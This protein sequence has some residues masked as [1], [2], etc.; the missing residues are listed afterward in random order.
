MKL[1][2]WRQKVHCIAASCLPLG[3]R[4]FGNHL[5]KQKMKFTRMA[6]MVMMIVLRMVAG[7]GVGDKE[8]S[9]HQD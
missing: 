4:T 6:V 1:F 8:S 3:S 2:L 5:Y 7:G 9:M